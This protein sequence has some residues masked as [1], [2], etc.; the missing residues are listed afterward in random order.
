MSTARLLVGLA[1][2]YNRRKFI[3]ILSGFR[4]I[5]DA[6]DMY[7]HLLGRQCR[8][9]MAQSSRV[10]CSSRNTCGENVDTDWTPRSRGSRDDS[11]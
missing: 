1:K 9:G 8:H 4:H 5:Q 2:C 6:T 10:R 3:A 11:A 7:I